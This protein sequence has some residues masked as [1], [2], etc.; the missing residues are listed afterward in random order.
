MVGKALKLF[1]AEKERFKQTEE[2]LRATQEKLAYL[3]NLVKA[4]AGTGAQP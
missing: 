1:K 4:R 2:E 3:Q